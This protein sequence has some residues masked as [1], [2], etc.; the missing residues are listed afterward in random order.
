[1]CAFCGLLGDS[2]SSWLEARPDN[3]PA[4]AGRLNRIKRANELLSL[5]R[6][7]LSDQHGAY[8]VLSGAT[9]KTEV[10]N[11]L[12]EAWPAAE[13]ILGK[14]L[15]PLSLDLLNRLETCNE[16]TKSDSF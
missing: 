4:R 16:S 7:T 9:G 8:Y 1:M 15:D 14:R 2:K 6:L 10:I 12:G 5:F 11:S 3:G 13:R